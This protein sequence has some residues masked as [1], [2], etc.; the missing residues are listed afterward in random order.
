[1]KKILLLCV[2][3]TGCGSFKAPSTITVDVPVYT[4]C[5]IAQIDRPD[6]A[7]DNLPIGSNIWEQMKALRAERIQREAYESI[8]EKA[9]QSCQA[10]DP[11][12]ADST[13]SY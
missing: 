6:L 4:P 3:V 11:A 2:L 7:V 13:T 5:V 10:S 8:L 1:M 9:I 12:G